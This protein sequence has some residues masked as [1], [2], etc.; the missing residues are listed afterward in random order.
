[1]LDGLPADNPLVVELKAVR[2]ELTQLR[3]DLLAGL[4]L[5]GAVKIGLLKSTQAI[6]QTATGV[7]AKA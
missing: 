7:T 6:A 2:D 4:K 1:M 3:D 5:D